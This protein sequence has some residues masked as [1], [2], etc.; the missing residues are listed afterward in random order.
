[1]VVCMGCHIEARLMGAALIASYVRGAVHVGQRAACRRCAASV[2][3]LFN[4]LVTK[5]ASCCFNSLVR[6]C[7]S[8]VA[9]SS[10]VWMAFTYS[11][12]LSRRTMVA[13]SKSRSSVLAALVGVIASFMFFPVG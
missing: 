6:L 10:A 11:V 3:T 9:R 7:T 4:S 12:T 13:A 1:M 2:S 5:A 8:A